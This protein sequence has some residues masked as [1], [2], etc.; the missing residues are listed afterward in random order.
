MRFLADMGVSLRVVSWLREQGH[1]A[2][3]LREGG[4]QRLAN[5]EIFK[6]A[7]LEKRILLTFDLGFGEI[8]ALSRGEKCS[9]IVFRLRNTRT[10]HVIA[11]L[12]AVL[13][14]SS[15]HLERGAV[16]IVEEARHRIRRLPVGGADPP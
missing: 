13:G 10:H 9:V 6:K 16:L 12:G 11:R 2:A 1:D 5:G 7:I 14:A 15:S 4:L 8:A 3:H